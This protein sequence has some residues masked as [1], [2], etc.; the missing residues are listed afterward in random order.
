MNI[1]EILPGVIAGYEFSE[2]NLVKNSLVRMAEEHKMN[3]EA[4]ADENDYLPFCGHSSYDIIKPI[5]NKHFTMLDLIIIGGSAAATA[6]GIY[7][8]RRGL[9]LKVITKEFGG[10]VATSGDIGN[11]PGDGMTDGIALSDK[12]KKHLQFYKVDIE[13]GVQVEKITK[14]ED[15]TFCISTN[16]GSGVTMADGKIPNDKTPVLKCDYVAKAVIV[17]T[18][19]HPRELGIPG[20]KEYRSKGLSYCSTCDMPL[21][22]GKTVTVIGGGNSALESALMGVDI[23]KKVYVINKNAT[24]KGDSVLLNK[25]TS[26]PKDKVEIIYEAKTKEVVGDKFVNGIKYTDKEGK[27]HEIKTDGI[28]VH[29]G[30]TPNSYIV[31]DD[32]EKNQFGEI[33][34]N[35]R[36]ETN[37]PGL[38]AAGD[39]S[40]VPF[41]Q[42]V[43]AAGQG[44]LATLSAVQYLNQMK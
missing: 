2:M 26:Q 36:C 23:A 35:T 33:K 7:G 39:V 27:E 28:F 30:M 20:E 9:N 43:V 37:I 3:Q 21:F 6:A 12:F 5:F 17:A 29:I 34:V 44:C 8:I 31:P 1:K 14:Q 4:Q 22:N 24:F 13:E 40:D 15:G 25:L 11:W 38:Y 10:E 19:V 42:I 32:V 18:G 16:R 41:K